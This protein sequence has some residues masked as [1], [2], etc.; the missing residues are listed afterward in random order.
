MVATRSRTPK[1]GKK[2]AAAV[3]EGSA[4]V[5]VKSK[6]PVAK[7]TKEKKAT[8]KKPAK[9][10]K[11]Q[12]PVEDASA[13]E[14]AVPADAGEYA[15]GGGGN[16]DEAD[17]E[18]TSSYDIYWDKRKKIAAA[19]AGLQECGIETVLSGGWRSRGTLQPK[20][21][22]KPK[23]VIEAGPVDR[24]R[25]ITKVL[26]PTTKPVS[27]R[28]WKQNPQSRH[29]AILKK[30]K[31]TNKRWKER[32]ERK[33]S[34]KDVKTLQSELMQAAGERKQGEREKREAKAKRRE[35][36]E[37]KSQVVQLVT[38]TRKLKKLNRK[39]LRQYSKW[40]GQQLGPSAIIE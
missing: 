4:A 7:K 38:N 9:F 30:T 22:A 23:T 39:Q 37:T 24:D 6:A 5:P 15:K 3:D 25:P 26:D 27:G 13:G 18:T 36:N 10:K 29:T 40:N 33:K 17:L 19:E 21:V 2:P 1:R 12:E 16:A 32:M 20:A 28:W 31:T 8:K 35:E 14:A 34:T 11:K